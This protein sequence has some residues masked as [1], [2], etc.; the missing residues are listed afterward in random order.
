MQ[1]LLAPNIQPSLIQIKLSHAIQLSF[2]RFPMRHNLRQQSPKPLT[3]V[4]L[5]DMTQLMQYHV[6]DT[7]FRGFNQMW[8]ED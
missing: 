6:V 5:F 1:G 4:V 7:F 3:V 2:D 8:I